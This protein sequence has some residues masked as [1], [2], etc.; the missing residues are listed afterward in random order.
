MLPCIK[1]ESIPLRG[2]TLLYP[3]LAARAFGRTGI[4]YVCAVTGAPVAAYAVMQSVRGS[5]TM[6]SAAFRARFHLSGLS[7]PYLRAYSSFHCLCQRYSIVSGLCLVY[8]SR[9]AM[10]RMHFLQNRGRADRKIC[11]PRQFY[12]NP[13]F[14]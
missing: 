9:A 3:D 11:P 5:K 6:F 13:A 7:V 4:R 12:W 8:P 10:S 2:T 14:S 1:D